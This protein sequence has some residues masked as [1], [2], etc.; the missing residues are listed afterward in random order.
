MKMFKDDHRTMKIIEEVANS[1]DDIKVTFD[2]QSLNCDNMVPILD[3][4]VKVN[5]K[6][7]VEHVFYRK[8]MATHL[9]THKDAA[10]GNRTK[11]TILTQECFR[12]IHN[13]SDNVCINMKVAIL[14]EFMV[15]L[16]LSGYDEDEREN[17]LVGG[18][19]RFS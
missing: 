10:L 5:D 1:L 14:D 18:E 15:D 17:K 11:F 13:T 7:Y 4:K 9:L 3:L 6:G 16:K 12:Q 19:R 8:P 2:V